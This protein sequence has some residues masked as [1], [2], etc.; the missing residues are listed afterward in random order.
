[1]TY[2]GN[3]WTVG[4]AH[5]LREE[6][7][8]AVD[9]KQPECYVSRELNLLA[10]NRRVLAPSLDPMVPLLERLR[11][12]C[13]SSSN[14]DEFFEIRVAGLM[15]QARLDAVQA[16]PGNLSPQEVLKPIT[17]QAHELVEAQY[18][19]LNDELLPTLA[20]QQ[21]RFVKRGQWN[22][23]QGAVQPRPVATSGKCAKGS[24]ACAA[25]R[26]Y[27]AGPPRPLRIFASALSDWRR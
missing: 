16:G 9:L 13:I 7:I 17:L 14:L 18:C 27:H 1:M 3:L 11:Y 25:Q 19:I 15:Q 4:L 10:F 20:E 26:A 23:A 24:R 8:D 2:S 22:K 21:I 5:R 12:L 6:E